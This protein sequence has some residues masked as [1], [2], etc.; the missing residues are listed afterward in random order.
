MAELQRIVK[1]GK[2]HK[3]PGHDCISGLVVKNFSYTAGEWFL[4]IVNSSLSLRHFPNPWK[5]ARVI[6]IPKPGK[7]ARILANFRPISLLCNMG[8][9]YEEV[10]LT[11]Y[12]HQ[13]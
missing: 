13:Y 11:G 6:P 2:S 3:A 12:D 7:S 8:K 4:T 10:V 1:K 9:N 5:L